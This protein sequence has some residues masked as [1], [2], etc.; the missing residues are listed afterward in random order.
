MSTLGLHLL[1]NRCIHGFD[2]KTQHPH[3]CSCAGQQLKDRGQAI[4]SAADEWQVFTAAVRKVAAEHGGE[5]DW[6]H[7]RP[8]IRGRVEPKHVGQFVKRARRGG[9]LIEVTHRRSEDHIGKNAGR[10]EPLYRIGEAA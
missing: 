5:V 9:L 2:L 6:T 1:P 3:L 8:L 10:L 4:T 7:V